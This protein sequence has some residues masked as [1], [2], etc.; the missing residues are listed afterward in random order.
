MVFHCLCSFNI[1]WFIV[2]TF[3]ILPALFSHS[4]EKQNTNE[5]ACLASGA[6][7]LCFLFC[8]L[9]KAPLQFHSHHTKL[10]GLD[11]MA[12][13]DWRRAFYL[14]IPCLKTKLFSKQKESILLT[15]SGTIV[16]IASLAMETKASLFFSKT[17]VN[18]AN[19]SDAQQSASK[20]L[21]MGR[22]RY[23]FY[24]SDFC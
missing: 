9:G 24:E 16:Q 21:K 4:V 13:E 8:S 5:K 18:F 3:K 15:A 11:H 2:K 22:N 17:K 7:Y 10:C 19:I 14:F 6:C 20:M 23:V 12:V 1:Y